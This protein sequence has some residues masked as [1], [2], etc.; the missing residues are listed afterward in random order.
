MAAVS[1]ATIVVAV[2]DQEE[3]LAWFTQKL[4]F[5]K[6]E[7]HVVG[8]MRWL[9]VGAPGDAVAFSLASWFPNNIGT[10][11]PLELQTD[12]CEATYRRLAANG[13]EFLETPEKRSYGTI[14]VFKDLSGNMYLLKQLPD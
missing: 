10:N 2:R 4:G 6:R 9:T 14:A 3:A 11:A 12:D 13:V 8:D 1:V 5:E 7:D